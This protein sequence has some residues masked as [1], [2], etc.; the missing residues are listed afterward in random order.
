LPFLLI[1]V[2]IA[3]SADC[4]NSPKNLFLQDFNV[5]MVKGDLSFVS[6]SIAKDIIWHL[7]E[8]SGQKE[9]QRSDGALK[10]YAN[11]LVIVPKEFVPKEFFI[12]TVISHGNT[13]AVNGIIKSKDGKSYVFCDV[14]KFS[15]H[16]KGDKIKEMTSCTIEETL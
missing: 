12:D 4:G 10:E 6:K 5:A 14:Y 16:A 9:I 13:G 15:S 3:I 11:N 7:Y 2:K 1:I 8:P